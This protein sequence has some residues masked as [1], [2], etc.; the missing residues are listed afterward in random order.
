MS[1]LYL[2]GF[3]FISPLLLF[4]LYYILVIVLSSAASNGDG[5]GDSRVRGQAGP[6]LPLEAVSRIYN[7][8]DAPPNRYDYFVFAE[9]SSYRCGGVLVADNVVL[10]AAHCRGLWYQAGIGLH[11]MYGEA[12]HES[13]RVL[14]EIPHPD[15]SGKPSYD[16]DIMVVLLDG[17]SR[18]SPVCMAES[19]ITLKVGED[20]TVMGFGKMETDNLATVLREAEAQYITNAYCSERYSGYLVSDNMLCAF[21]KTGQDACQGDSGGPLIR[22]GA[23]ATDD[24]AVGIVSWGVDCGT[25]PGVYTRISRYQDWIE[26]LVQK[27]GGTICGQGSIDK[28]GISESRSDGIASETRQTND[29]ATSEITSAPNITSALNLTSAPN[30]TSSLTN[31]TRP[32]SAP[33]RTPRPT[34]SKPPTDYPTYGPTPFPT[35]SPTPGPTNVPTRAPSLGP[36]PGPISDPTKPPTTSPTSR[37]TGFPT[38]LPSFAPT[39]SP[40]EIWRH[41]VTEENTVDVKGYV[42]I[43]GISTKCEEILLSALHL[44]CR[45]EAVRWQCP[46]TCDSEYGRHGRPQERTGS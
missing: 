21:S 37:P 27:N 33:T 13:I 5:S 2:I 41:F 17:K 34:R 38:S 35:T 3:L 20:L 40:T 9:N 30:I 24:L 14:K 6:V 42:K 46:E 31:T 29:T 26:P 16:N 44:F 36:T 43:N 11:S 28:K 22:R 8:Q 45:F 12:D 4:L 15:Y 39:A 23:D 19:S 25:M 32:T 7:G 18:V 1:R 10:S